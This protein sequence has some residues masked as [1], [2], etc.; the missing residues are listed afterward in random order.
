MPER[1]QPSQDD[2]PRSRLLL[3]DDEER[4]RRNLAQRLEMRGFAVEGVGDGEE[5]IRAVRLRRPDVVLLDLKMPRMQGEE[6]LGELKRIAPE[7]QVVILTGHA[8]IES[9]TS[10]GRMDAFAYLEKPCEMEILVSTIE[11]ARREKRHAMARQE[12]PHVEERSVVRWLVGTH[13]YRPGAMIAGALLLAAVV[14]APV[15]ASMIDLFGSRKTGTGTEAI[16][17][18]PGYRDMEAGDT[19][20]RYYSETARRRVEIAGKGGMKTERA[21]TA[22]ETGRKAKAMLGILLLAAFFWATGAVHVGVTALLVATLMYGF[23]IY[24]P[25]LVA[26]AF[27]KDAVIFMAGILAMTSAVSRTGLDRRIGLALVGTGR[28]PSL[29]LFVL[30]PL[31]CLISS[32]LSEHALTVVLVPVLMAVYL[33]AVR[34]AG[35]KKDR[36]LAAVFILGV[37]FAA[38]AGGPGS[39]AAGG[40]NAVMIGILAD[41]GMAPSFAQ[42]V[43]YGLPF[44]PVA[45][46]AISLYLYL[47]LGRSIR[48][49]DLDIR[50]TALK[51]Y[52]KIGS[53]TRGEYA[54]ACVLAGVIVLWLTMSDVLGM[55]GP[56]ILGLVALAVLR[57]LAWRDV[58]RIS[59][60]VVALYASAIAISSGLAHTGA[61]TWMAGACLEALPV[62][63]RT[64]EGLA[65]VSSLIAGIVTNFM[66][67]G[68]TVAVV[69][70]VA[71]PMAAAGGTHPWMVGFATAFA[72]SFANAL[73][74]AT[75]NNAIAYSLAK[76]PATGEQLVTAADFLKH[77]TFVTIISWAVLWG[78]CIL[79]YWRWMGFG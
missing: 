29:F 36:A 27:V 48:V 41:H 7:V 63:L 5:A 43:K 57:I 54:T 51:E 3:V 24:P 21:L 72:S 61:A 16:S 55:G 50:E 74:I 38:N 31:L 2:S 35:I 53:T 28:S 13:S 65:V 9:A 45:A 58:N 1:V 40:R 46:I 79:G 64:G 19:I 52:A 42:W 37:C 18:Y 73:V 25:D 34:A 32:F 30:L 6:V 67:D 70:P 8:S 22:E 75:P 56:V 33:A 77:G 47:A 26:R 11:S 71:V 69:G 59:W 66:S 12:I 39:P 62:H 10:T 49:K 15:P 76:D 44:V 4:F 14:A 23:G 17:G 68:A 20:A 60:D 78:W